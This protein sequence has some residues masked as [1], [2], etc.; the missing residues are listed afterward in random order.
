MDEVTRY[1]EEISKKLD[2]QS[3]QIEKQG[4]R[5]DSM[6]KTINQIALQDQEI[7]HLKKELDKVRTHVDD[8]CATDGTLAKMS[9]FQA[10]CPRHQLKNLWLVVIPMCITQLA[11]GVA[12]IG[13]AVKMSGA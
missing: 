13:V 2:A 1:W 6:Q 12:V 9:R 10:S 4:D 7:K 8:L 3:T 11:V 5:L